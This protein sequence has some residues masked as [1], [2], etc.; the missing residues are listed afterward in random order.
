MFV[1]FRNG[2]TVVNSG[3]KDAATSISQSRMFF[4]HFPVLSA[5]HLRQ[6]DAEKRHYIH[7]I[8]DVS[9]KILLDV[10]P[11]KSTVAEFS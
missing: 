9:E 10:R 8:L 6:K 1:K 3:P 2:G 5:S 7:W 11:W 4:D